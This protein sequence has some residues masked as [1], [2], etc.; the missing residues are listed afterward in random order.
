VELLCCDKV[1]FV[2]NIVNMWGYLLLGQTSNTFISF[3]IAACATTWLI[4]VEWV[5][6]N[7]SEVCFLYALDAIKM[8]CFDFTSFF[9]LVVNF[10]A[11]Y[12]SI[13]G[14]DYHLNNDQPYCFYLPR[15]MCRNNSTLLFIDI[16]VNWIQRRA[17][18]IIDTWFDLT[19]YYL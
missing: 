12:W 4:C 1:T 14:N 2:M 8:M 9:A 11:A 7:S 3:G 5:N 15:N 6:L 10:L 17:V 16:I 19:K 18:C 13:S